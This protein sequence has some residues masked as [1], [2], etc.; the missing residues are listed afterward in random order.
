MVVLLGSLS[1]NAAQAD[2]WTL[3]GES[4]NSTKFYVKTDSIKKRYSTESY[5]TEGGGFGTSS[6][7]TE[8]WW[9]T[10]DEDGSY[11]K[12]K[13]NFFCSTDVSKDISKV[14]Y[15]ATG[16]SIGSPRVNSFAFS[17]VPDTS[18]SNVFSF[19]CR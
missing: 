18:F 9:K 19:V 4:I 5:L 12:V 16:R 15:S 7:H 13:T 11:I 6:Q 1:S 3:I 2:S 8:A 17:T 14:M 10:V